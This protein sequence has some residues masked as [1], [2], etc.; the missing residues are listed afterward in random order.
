PQWERRIPLHCA[1]MNLWRGIGLCLVL[2][3]A[4]AQAREPI[5]AAEQVRQMSRGVNIVGYD[6][7]WRDASQARF[8][9]RHFKVIHDGGFN[10]VRIVLSAFRFMNE[11]N[12]LPASW[13]STL[14]G[15]IVQSLGVEGLTV[16]LDEHDYWSCGKD[17]DACR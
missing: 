8:K 10:S 1:P 2:A 7:L 6:P 11:K 17:V 9:P 3:A 14:D 13:F 15:L 12:E 16:I 4:A 5:S